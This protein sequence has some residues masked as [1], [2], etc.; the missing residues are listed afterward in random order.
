MR[1]LIKPT[2]LLLTLMVCAVSASSLIAQ[3]TYIGAVKCGLCHKSEKSG[4]QLAAWQGSKHAK[5]FETLNTPAADEIAK[6]KGL[7]TKAAVSADCLACHTTGGPTSG[8]LPAE[9]VSCEACHNAGSG[10]KG[11]AV[12][13]NKA[14]A[15]AAGMQKYDT[16]AAIEA[17]CRTCHNEKSPTA[18]AF[19]FEESWAK[20]KHPKPAAP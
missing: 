19:V 18:K 3:A 20:I 12:M 4:N 5:A 13:K 1:S 15:I 8:I 11:L 14:A 6:G 16:P 17:Q 9:G 2:T 7:T 10:Y